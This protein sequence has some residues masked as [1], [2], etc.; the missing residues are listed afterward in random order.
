MRK[1]GYSFLAAGA[2]LLALTASGCELGSLFNSGPPAV[3]L[4]TAGNFAILAKTEISTVPVSD[5]TG[6]IGLSPAAESFMTGFAQTKATGY[7]TSD[8]V[9]GFMYAAD[10]T[11]PTPTNL[12]ATISEMEAA[13]ADAAGRTSPDFL[14]LGLGTLDGLVLEPGLYKWAGTV[15]VNAPITL[16]GG[17]GDVWI[18]QMGGGLT[19]GSSGDVIMSGG[20]QAKNVFWQVAG[21][22]TLGAG[23]H[24]EG[25]ILCASDISLL[26]GASLTG[27][28]LSQTGVS[29][30]QAVVVIP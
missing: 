24:M 27:R 12:T 17:S 3:E 8:Q 7:S 4:G 25:I 11:E 28:A 29:L 2:A 14:E 10:S 13:Y 9:T 6:D 30:V 21:S 19:E 5:I 20:A 15:T 1:H 26:A 18:F 23:A 22:A 16:D